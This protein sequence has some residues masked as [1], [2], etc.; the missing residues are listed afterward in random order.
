MR[1]GKAWFIGGVLVMLSLCVSCGKEQAASDETPETLSKIPT[2]DTSAV[3][4]ILQAQLTYDGQYVMSVTA[5]RDFPVD[6]LVCDQYKPDG[7]LWQKGVAIFFKKRGTL[8]AG[9]TTTGIIRPEG[10]FARGKL[11]LRLKD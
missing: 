6:A 4:A 10:A 11:A 5:K 7:D 3:D 1:K 2:L 9:E 8:P